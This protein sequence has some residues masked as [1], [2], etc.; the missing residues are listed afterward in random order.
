MQ[1]SEKFNKDS[2]G[3]RSYLQLE[4]MLLSGTV[5]QDVCKQYPEVDPSHL[6]LQLATFS[7]QNQYTTLQQ[8]QTVMQNMTQ[9]V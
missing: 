3:L 5:N 1:L 2:V 7:D 6:S 9:E 4:A 8:A